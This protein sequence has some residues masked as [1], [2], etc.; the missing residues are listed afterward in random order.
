MAGKIAELKMS[1]NFEF[2]TLRSRVFANAT[3][4]ATKIGSLSLD[5]SRGFSE[6]DHIFQQTQHVGESQK[7]RNPE[8]TTFPVQDVKSPYQDSQVAR[9]SL[10][11][12]ANLDFE[13]FGKKHLGSQFLTGHQ[14]S[15]EKVL[16]S[17]KLAQNPSK[18]FG[19]S[20]EH[21]FC[22]ENPTVQAMN[23]A[24]GSCKSCQL[25]QLSPVFRL[26]PV[27]SRQLLIFI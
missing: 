17:E 3:P 24:L 5:G 22:S 26:S 12:L 8:C 14:K 7:P 27:H 13:V 20:S 21:G 11:D 16:K 4:E 25:S 2:P 15:A 19:D 10:K 9:T 18:T 1:W 23:V 6:P